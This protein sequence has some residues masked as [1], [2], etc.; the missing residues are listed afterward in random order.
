MQPETLYTFFF[1]PTGTSE[2]I[3]RAV[4]RGYGADR[5]E[6]I[7]L[8][9]EGTKLKIGP[10]S[11]AV[12]AVPVYGGRV[13]PVAL[14]RLTSVSGC[15]TPVVLIALYGNRAYEKTLEQLAAFVSERGFIPIA[16]AAFVGEHSYS[17]AEYPIAAGRPDLSDIDRAVA[18]GRMVRERSDRMDENDLKPVDLSKLKHPRNSFLSTIRFI[19]FVLGWRRK[20]KKRKTAVLPVTDPDRCLHCGRCVSLCPVQA[21]TEGDELHTDPGLCI[22]C[23]ACV[24]GCRSHARTLTSPFAPVLSA[25]FSKPK[26]PVMRV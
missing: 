25:C 14:E 16:V 12:I 6:V 9:R 21:I 13:A 2:K 17:T 10:S 5:N 26:R 23:C 1:S 7:D 22:K 19:R 3:A 8:T 4:S 11:L 18:F 24:K 20:Q 15:R